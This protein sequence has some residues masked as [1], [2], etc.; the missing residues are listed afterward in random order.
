MFGLT[1]REQRWKAE[2]E[3]AALLASVAI[4]ARADIDVAEANGKAVADAKELEQLRAENL[5]LKALVGE[6]K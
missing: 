2:Q 1:K 6:D 5:R 4:K 3:A